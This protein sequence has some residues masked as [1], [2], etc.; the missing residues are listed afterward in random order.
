MLRYLS[1]QVWLPAQNNDAGVTG[2]EGSCELSESIFS[3][4]RSCM[5]ARTQAQPHQLDSDVERT[6]LLRLPKEKLVDLLIG[7][8]R[9]ASAGDGLPRVS[10]EK[11]CSSS[12]D[13]APG[14]AIAEAEAEADEAEGETQCAADTDSATG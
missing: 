14:V 13:L 3:R 4:T 11:P 6:A 1:E 2:F 5:Q 9:A 8:R 12:L 7:E 10:G